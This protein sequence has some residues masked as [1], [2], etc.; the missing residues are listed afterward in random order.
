MEPAVAFLLAPRSEVYLNLIWPDLV[1]LCLRI[2]IKLAGAA[3]PSVAFAD[4]SPVSHSLPQDCSTSASISPLRPTQSRSRSS[5]T[6]RFF[7]LLC[8]S[9]TQES[10]SGHI[11][12]AY[13]PVELAISAN[14]FSRKRKSP[15]Q[16]FRRR[17]MSTHDE[18]RGVN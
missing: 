3:L 17:N 1:G 16:A 6:V 14:D 10:R 13:L 12:S 11:T 18:Y 4:F 2:F 15:I 8:Q 5:Y 9:F 7:S